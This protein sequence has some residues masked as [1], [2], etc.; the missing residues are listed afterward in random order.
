MIKTIKKII[1]LLIW[2]YLYIAITGTIF[3][4]FWNFNILSLENWNLIK[5]YWESGGI[6]HT[7]KDYLFLFMLLAYIPLWYKGWISI[8]KI[9]F[10]K[11]ILWPIEKYNQ[12]IIKGYDSTSSHI[13]IKNMGKEGIKIEEEIEIKSKPKTQIQTDAEVNKI[14]E[15][16]ASKINSVKHK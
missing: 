10:L 4:Y 14:R 8:Q 16:V 15:A 2:T 1:T 13:T 7:W 11:I 9:N 3:I 5:E 6:I 12:H